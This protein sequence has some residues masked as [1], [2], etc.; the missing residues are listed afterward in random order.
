M[1]EGMVFIPEIRYTLMLSKS[2]AAE[3]PGISR[4]EIRD[5]LDPLLVEIPGRYR[6]QSSH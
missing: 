1:I 2:A 4:I 5:D 3:Y 6:D